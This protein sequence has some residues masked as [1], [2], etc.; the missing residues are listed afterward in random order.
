LIG[1][2]QSPY[3]P[4][5]P[6]DFQSSLRDFSS[7]E[8]LPRTASW[9]KFSRPCGTQFAVDGFSRR[10]FSP[11]GSI[12]LLGFGQR[13]AAQ[14][15]SRTLPLQHSILDGAWI[16]QQ[17]KKLASHLISGRNR[18]NPR[19]HFLIRGRADAVSKG[20]DQRCPARSLRTV[21]IGTMN[22]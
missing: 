14:P 19:Q 17:R 13:S 21:F 4:R 8:S 12:S 2:Y 3:T 11:C 1:N 5:F 18:R 15:A 20:V 9:P 10:L 16:E 22:H 7:L 6:G